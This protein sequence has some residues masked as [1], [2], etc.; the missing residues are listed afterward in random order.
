MTRRGPLRCSFLRGPGGTGVKN[1]PAKAGGAFPWRRKW[2]PTPVSSLE[3]P[4]GRGA[5]QATVQG[6]AK[7]QT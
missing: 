1:L 2:Q 4:V 7:S 3:N 6:V 5:W